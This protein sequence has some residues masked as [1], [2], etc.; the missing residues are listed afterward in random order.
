MKEYLI[1]E[2]SEMS[3]LPVSTIRYYEDKGILTNVARNVSGQRVF[4]EGH[5]NRLRTICCFKN[6]GMTI[7]EL[8]Q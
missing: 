5:V 6:T 4:T 8:R 3:G 2:I 1:R 7:A